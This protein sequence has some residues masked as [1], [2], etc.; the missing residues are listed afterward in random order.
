MSKILCLIINLNPIYDKGR[1]GWQLKPSQHQ[2]FVMND[3]LAPPPENRLSL[4]S[5]P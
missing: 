3:I 1:Q 4:M 5:Q 2:A